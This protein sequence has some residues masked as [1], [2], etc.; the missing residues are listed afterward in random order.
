[1]HSKTEFTNEK[2][3]STAENI[4][5]ELRRL[6]LNGSLKPG[7]KLTEEHLCKDLHVSRTPL[8]E[9]FRM[10]QSE[11]LLTYTRYVGVSVAQLSA[12]FL[13][14]NWDIRALL[15][16][17]AAKMVV[18]NATRED[19]EELYQLK[20]IMLE[21]K[22]ND[23]EK[24]TEYDKKFHLTIAKL[25]G[26]LE[27][28][29][30]IKRMWDNALTLRIIAVQNKNRIARSCKEHAAVIQAI[31]ERDA[32]KAVKYMN[33]HLNKSKKDIFESHFFKD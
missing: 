21:I 16:S 32:K 17:Y 3:H 24:F 22:P 25:S 20:K 33:E 6:I 9:A 13:E 30:L 23:F 31:Y 26:N 14:D 19:I 15:E 12:K 18:F 27:L 4:A 1:M 8:R 5:S 7:T 28:E 10:L 2:R 11:K 29:N